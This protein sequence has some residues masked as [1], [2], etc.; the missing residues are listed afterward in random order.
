MNDFFHRHIKAIVWIFRIVAGGTFVVSGLTKM[1]DVWGFIYKIEQ[2]LAVWDMP[3]PRS[4]VLAV[5]MCLSGAEFLLGCM[6]ATGCYKRTSAWFMTLVMLGMLPLTFYIMVAEPVSECGCFGDFLVI[7]NTATFLKNV[8]LTAMLG[9]LLFNNR[10]VD[11]LFTS[12]SQWLVA[13]VAFLYILAVGL[14]GYHVQPLIDFRP[15]KA[16]TPILPDSSVADDDGSGLV[17]VYEKNGVTREFGEDELPDS[18]WSYVD[19]RETGPSEATAADERA[20]AVYEGDDDVTS[21]VIG[22]EGVQILLLIPELANIDV[23]STYLINEMNRYVSTTGGRM[24]GIIG[25]DEEGLDYWRDISLASYELYTADD[26]AIKELARGNV[27]VVYLKDGIIRW[28]RSLNSIDSDTFVSPDGGTLERLDYS[29][30]GYFWLLTLVFA[31]AE[32]F[33]W[34]IDRSGRAV[35]LHFTRRKRKK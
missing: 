31:G 13:F 10:K 26:T 22:G 1:I 8:V 9:Y 23:S 28:K 18:T 5:A 4:L 24:T 29:G 16:G 6:M 11:G 17:F 2:Y 25:T 3:Q 20:L 19:R 15:Y 33:L 14:F 35:K 12:Y 30:T 34:G 32:L 7:S 21:E 27:A